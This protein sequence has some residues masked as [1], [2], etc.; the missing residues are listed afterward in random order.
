MSIQPTHSLAVS[1]FG[2]IAV[3]IVCSSAAPAASFLGFDERL[4]CQTVIEDWRHAQRIWPEDN[5]TAKPERSDILGDAMIMARVRQTDHQEA[6][7]ANR[8]GWL[9]NAAQLQAELN[10]IARSS[11]MPQ[12]LAELFA[13]LDNDAVLIAECVARPILVERHLARLE[14]K[15]SIKLESLQ[16]VR[17]AGAS[18]QAVTG[19]SLA[20]PI[21]STRTESD[22]LDSWRVMDFPEGRYAHSSIWTGSEMIIWGGFSNGAP[23]DTGSRYDPLTDTWTGISLN[24]APSARGNPVATWTG[25]HMLVWGGNVS[26]SSQTNSGGRYD[27]VADQWLPISQDGAPTARLAAASVWTGTEWLIWGGHAPPFNVY[28]DGARYNP[29]SDTWQPISM[30]QAPDARYN[31]QAVWTGGEMLIWGGQVAGT[32]YLGS[33]A[34]YNPTTDSWTETN[35]IGAPSPRTGHTA[36]WADKAM[37]IWGGRDPDNTSVNTGAIYDPVTDSWESTDTAGTPGTRLWHKAVWTGDEM[38]VWGGSWPAYPQ[39]GG[40]FDPLT[41]SW[42]SMS[43]SNAPQG[44]ESHTMVWTGEELVIWGGTRGSGSVL[45]SGARYHPESDSWQSINDHN[46][47]PARGNHVSVW[48]GSEKLI[49]GGDGSNG[50]RY[51]PVLDTWTSMN[52]DNA[53]LGRIRT[54]A[55]WTGTE[56]II[57]GGISFSTPRNTG[58]RYNPS[59]DSWQP[60]SLSDVP[61]PRQWHSAVWNGEHMIVWGGQDSEYLDDGGLY[62]PLTDQWLPLVGD[63]PPLARVEHTAVWTGEEML[64]WGG[65]QGL[66]VRLNSGARYH[67][68]TQTW[69]PTSLDDVPAARYHHSAVWTGS[70]LVVW[71]GNGGGQT[72]GVYDP[73]TDSWRPTSMDNVPIRRQRGQ[74][75]AWT[76][77]EMI[78]WGGWSTL[79]TVTGGRYDP[80]TDSWRAMSLRGVPGARDAATAVWTG[81]EMVVW[82]G[83]SNAVAIYD[84]ELPLPEPQLRILSV[85]P[86]PSRAGETVTIVVEV[87]DAYGEAPD[88]G[89]V[90]VSADTGE[91]C[92]DA[93]PPSSQQA[94]ALFACQITFSTMGD[95]MLSASFSGSASHADLDTGDADYPHAVVSNQLFTLSGQT[96]GLTGSGLELQLNQDEILAIDNEGLFSFM[97][98]LDDAATW[99]LTVHQQPTGPSQTC[100]IEPLAGQ[101]D[102]ADVDDVAVVCQTEFFS[103]GG[104]VSGLE[105]EGLTLELNNTDGLLIESDGSFVFPTALID[106]SAYLVTVA[107]Q[108]LGPAQTC[109]VDNAGGYLDGGPVENVIVVCETNLYRVGGLV[110][111]LTGQGLLLDNNGLEQHAINGNGSFHFPTLHPQGT[112][113]E[114]IILQQPTAPAQTC[115]VDGGIGEVG[116]EHVTSIEVD[117]ESDEYVITASAGEGGSI[118][119]AGS[120][121]VAAGEPAVFELAADDGF[122]LANVAGSCEGQLD[123]MTYTTV[124]VTADCTIEAE[125]VYQGPAELIVAVSPGTSVVD[126][127]LR[128]QLVVHVLNIDQEI[129][130][131]D[132]FTVVIVS[133]SDHVSNG[134]LSGTLQ[135]QASGGV[136]I[137]DDLVIDQVGEGYVL[138]VVDSKSQLIPGFSELFNVVEDRVFSDRFSN[139]Q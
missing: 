11:R 46:A 43:A 2:A 56:M 9:I 131:D 23:L 110:S 36:V 91:T 21:I 29:H 35:P 130:E 47:P 61:S 97:T 119:P 137:F 74:V 59:T 45:T 78:V 70:E 138:E 115:S 76:G 93:G 136:I 17:H 49:W 4:A 73:A 6:I 66:S 109:S 82:G 84:P 104:E 57:W 37:I 48:T 39:G 116:V 83:H 134:Q 125:F 34:R 10:R 72:G 100:S 12:R 129:V 117:C 26:G 94:S 99:A 86:S 13:L 19:I 63:D 105:G 1:V 127:P 92:T 124:P 41:N 38:L 103:I 30:E 133:L 85:Q 135:R 60:T 98:G 77:T 54:S 68:G 122:H 121:F 33:G 58:G 88:D 67:P 55:V 101:I 14:T 16:P 75:T 114:V 123:G 7:L 31:H 95:R 112:P 53:P 87:F 25:T 18:L 52:I 102:G 80:A 44:R 132:D 89:Q 139:D 50:S 113:Y 20:L 42:S 107:S 106:G 120:V 65:R 71:S 69:T 64:I 51:D 15:D 90:L 22:F 128:P 8:Y 27:P 62:D 118:T 40:R 96:T 28:G 108:P 32:S 3:S 24:N 126:W 5:A 111:G 79:L 81:N